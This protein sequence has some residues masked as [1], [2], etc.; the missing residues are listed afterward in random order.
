[1]NCKDFREMIDSY[2]SDELLTETNHDVLRHMENCADCRSVIEARREIRSRLKSAVTNAPQYQLNKNFE[3][4]L[5][6]QLRHA[7]FETTETQTVSWFGF[8][9]LIAVAAGLILTITLGLFL[10]NNLGGE[11][12]NVAGETDK[13]VKEYTVPTLPTNHIV[14]IASGDHEHCAIRHKLEEA[15]ISLAKASAQYDG[16]EKVITKPLANAL[17]NYELVEAHA[18]KYKKT[19]FAH[20][21]LQNAKE[22]LSVLI[23]DKNDSD[24]LQNS[25]IL[26]YST[27]KY[28]I[29]RFDVKDKAIF[30]VSNLN[31]QKNSKAAEALYQPLRN[32]FADKE[33][34]QTAILMVY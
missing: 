34:I 7:A 9:S 13:E 19:R 23:T 30:V 3:H 4:N 11:Q 25:G 26:N 12:P 29:A 8:K 17:T 28:E 31:K 16:I 33:I 10:I 32:H 5:R 24:D 1:M 20:M 21:V 6:T 27:K 22:T 14:N 15:P 2:L 18:C